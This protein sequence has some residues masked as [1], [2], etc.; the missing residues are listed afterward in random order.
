MKNIKQ[1]IVSIIFMLIPSLYLI[2]I[3]NTLP[4]TVPIHWNI[5]GEIDNY[6]SR[7][8]LILVLFLLP[9]LTYILMSIIPLIDPKNKLKNMGKKFTM[10]KIFLVGFMSFLATFIFYITKNNHPIS[11]SFIFSLIGL[12]YIILG[13]YFPTLKHNYFIGIRTPWT[14]ENETVWKQTH[15]MAG[16]YWLFGGILIILSSLIFKVELLKIIMLSVTAIIC[17]VP[18]VFSYKI[19]KKN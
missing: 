11:T 6:G 14:L 3:W 12:L 15:Q 5:K 4:E 19:S 16:K 13:N 10:L 1:E 18:I 9:Y 8:M 7:K 2:S 17:I